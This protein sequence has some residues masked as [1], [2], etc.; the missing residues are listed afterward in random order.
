M[1]YCRVVS[2]PV[3]RTSFKILIARAVM[4]SAVMLAVSCASEDGGNDDAAQNSV[5]TAVAL[6][7][8][9][10]VTTTQNDGSD[11]VGDGD[12]DT[13]TSGSSETDV[14]VV[15]PQEGSL[16]DEDVAVPESSGQQV[17]VAPQRPPTIDDLLER[18][19]VLNIAHAGGDQDYP[20]S[21]LYAMAQAVEQGADALEI[22]VQL[23][24][25]GVLVVQHDDTVD[26]T[27]GSTGPVA[28]LTFDEL[29]ALDNAYWFSPECWPCQD[30][31]IDEY[32]WRGVR[33]GDQPPPDGFEPADFAVPSLRQLAERFPTMPLIIEI[34]G[35]HPESLPAVE[36][37]AGELVELDRVE[38]T[39]V[40]SFDD[41]LIDAFEELVPAVEVSPGLDELTAWVL[42][43]APLDGRRIVQVPPEFNGVPVVSDAFWKLA[44][45]SGVDVWI[46][47]SDAST[48][49]NRE[50][51]TEM[52]DQGAA[53]II[54]GRPKDMAAA[55]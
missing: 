3:K 4:L 2:I 42:A 54:A 12:E 22:D 53:G 18:D 47:P 28:A 39:V 37:L 8:S 27:T 13:A 34:K 44:A 31:P 15:E 43:G 23:T 51:Y 35:S 52:I 9:A 14:A 7:Q 1:P 41:A 50:F 21:T 32:V 20:H 11:E 16:E 33:T 25:D 6:E 36:A 46:W 49:E 40:V 26:K 48:Q 38:S 17:E 55:S 45:D 29:H 24:G 10:S 5:E 30:R 19:D